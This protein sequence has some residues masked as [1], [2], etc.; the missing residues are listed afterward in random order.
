MANYEEARVKL[1][2]TQPK[3]IESATKNKTG[4][5]LIIT[6]KNLQYE[7][8]PYELFLTTRQKPK[9][10]EVLANNMFTDKRLSKA[11][12]GYLGKTLVH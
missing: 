4:A 3:K 2:N 12:E 8:L 7:E 9:I 1:A 10:R 11:Q 6:K 5:K